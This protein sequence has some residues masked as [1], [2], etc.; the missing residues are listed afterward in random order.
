LP[1]ADNA[2]YIWIQAYYSALNAKGRAG[3]VMA[4]SAADAGGSE[5]EIRKRLIA[6]KAVDVV[7]SVAS[8]F[9]YMVTLPVTLWFL[10]RG[11]LGTQRRDKVLFIDARTIFN[12]IDRAHRDWLPEQIEFLANIAR[13]YRGE[14]WETRDGSLNLMNASFPDGEYVDVP[15]LCR[16]ATVDEI[17]EQGWS[18]NPGRYVGVAAVE[19]DG[20]DFRVQLQELSE[21]LEKL[22]GEAARL[23]ERVSANVAKLLS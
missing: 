6:E 13:L 17:E 1:K 15:G 20:I 14:G 23:Q 21:E 16:M 4:N 2:N 10:D 5:L 11:K 18:L 19:D 12:Q 8:N 3:F 9:F 22:N 7:V